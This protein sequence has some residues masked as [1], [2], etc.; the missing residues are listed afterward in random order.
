MSPWGLKHSVC[1]ASSATNVLDAIKA[2]LGESE[3][4]LVWVESPSNPMLKVCPPMRN[5]EY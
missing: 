2:A 3:E 1:D 5:I 4:V